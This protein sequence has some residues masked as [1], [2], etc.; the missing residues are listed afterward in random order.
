MLTLALPSAIV[1]ESGKSHNIAAVP[2]IYL[3]D[4]FAQVVSAFKVTLPK[5]T[6]RYLFRGNQIGQYHARLSIIKL[7][8][9]YFVE[10]DVYPSVNLARYV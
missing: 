4:H 8:A 2:K 1:F 10:A 5:E 3:V 6:P 7:R 9:K